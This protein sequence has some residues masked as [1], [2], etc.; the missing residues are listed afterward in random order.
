VLG[1]GYD[2]GAFEILQGAGVRWETNRSLSGGLVQLGSLIAYPDATRIYDALAEGR[3]D[4]F[5][6]ERPIFHWAANASD[7]PW[8]GRLEIVPNGL[9]KDLFPYVAGAEDSPR[10]HAL[11]AEVN[12]FLRAFEGT[13][14]QLQIERNWQGTNREN[15]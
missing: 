12:A 14:R 6:V 15:P 9:I 2:P 5:F 10:G 1:C 13:P 11:L 4:A 3:V 8:V 7:S